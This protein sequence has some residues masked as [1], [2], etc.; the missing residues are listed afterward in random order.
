MKQFFRTPIFLFVSGVFLWGQDTP[1][2]QAAPQTPAAE[3]T[4]S[5]K[6]ETKQPFHHLSVG[7]R[8]R[9]FPTR[10]MSVMDSQTVLTTTTPVVTRDWNFTTS[11]HSPVWGIGPAIEYAVNDRLTF[12]LEVMYNK[13]NYS[14]VTS[15]AWGTDD[16]TTTADE[17]THMFRNETTKANLFDVPLMVHYKGLRPTGP[18]SRMFVAAGVSAR[19]VSSIKTTLVTTFPDTSTVTTNVS[20]APSKRNMLGGVVGLGFRVVDDFNIHWTPEVRFTRWAG[21]TFSSDSTVSPRNQLEVGL[22]ITF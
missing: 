16:P 4:P 1:Q 9:D 19:A 2:T 5:S 11:S 22:G 15:I 18:L 7:L 12:T 14:K 21:S 13:L 17:R 3:Q 20:A 8:A 10:S 6:R